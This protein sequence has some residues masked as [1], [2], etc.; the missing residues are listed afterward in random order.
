MIYT[1]YNL[2]DA[3]V[4][5][6]YSTI[7]KYKGVDVSKETCTEN[8]FQTSNMLDLFNQNLLKK[9]LPIKEIYDGIFHMHYIK[10]S[11]GG[12]QKEHNHAKTEQYSCIIYLNNADDGCTVLK[13][14]V[15]KKIIPQK[16]KVIVFD[17][18]ISHFAEKSFGGKEIIVGA[19]NKK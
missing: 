7:Y 9:I 15:N 10:Y 8:G 11:Q 2:E 17:A 13:D 1:E 3:T 14:P 16:G 12:F 5:K 4:D 19:I 6:I 18:K